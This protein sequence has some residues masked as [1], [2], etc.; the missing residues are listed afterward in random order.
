MNVNRSVTG[1]RGWTIAIAA[2]ALLAGSI[3]NLQAQRDRGVSQPGAAGNRGVDPGINQPG[4]AG[5]VGGVGRD[6]GI[7]QPGRAGNVGVGGSARQ[8]R[9][10]GDP[11][12][13]QPGAVGNYGRDHGVNQPGAAGNRR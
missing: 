1:I 13:N 7:N 4:R 6:P 8:T 2:A 3:L 9:A 5:N 10:V 12:I 11:G